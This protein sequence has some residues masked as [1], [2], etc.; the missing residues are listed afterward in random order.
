MILQEKKST[1]S[2]RKQIFILKPEKTI[3]K[4]FNQK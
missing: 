1:N 4:N 3:I 2:A